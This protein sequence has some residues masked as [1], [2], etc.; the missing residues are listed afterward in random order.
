LKRIT[1]EE[2]LKQKASDIG[3]Q[4]QKENGVAKAVQLINELTKK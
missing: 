3:S 4:M 2:H 1:T